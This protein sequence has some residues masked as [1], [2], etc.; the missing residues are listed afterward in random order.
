M[1]HLVAQAANLQ[2]HVDTVRHGPRIKRADAKKHSAKIQVHSVCLGIAELSAQDEVRHA[3]PDIVTVQQVLQLQ[4]QKRPIPS[5]SFYEV[6]LRC[7]GCKLDESP[8]SPPRE[9]CS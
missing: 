5:L 9:Q 6:E 3:I 8:A 1:H 2:F 7:S 4:Q